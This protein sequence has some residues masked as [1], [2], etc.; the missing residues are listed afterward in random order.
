MNASAGRRSLNDCFSNCKYLFHNNNTQDDLC[1]FTCSPP[2]VL[3]LLWDNLNRVQPLANLV[4]Q[5]LLEKAQFSPQ[6]I[7]KILTEERKSDPKHEHHDIS[8]VG[9]QEVA[10]QHD[11]YH[12][13]GWIL[14]LHPAEYI[15]VVWYP[16][17]PK[18]HQDHHGTT[19]EHIQGTQKSGAKRWEKRKKNR[20]EEVCFRAFLNCVHAANI[21]LAGIFSAR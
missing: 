9:D 10:R 19:N 7:A 14:L 11:D 2:P 4:S 3:I 17:E 13:R 15:L 5:D 20:E 1:C 12:K 21:Q 8:Q 18:E 16:H 6:R